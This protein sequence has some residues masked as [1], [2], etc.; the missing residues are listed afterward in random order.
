MS[1]LQY[2]KVKKVLPSP[3]GPL[4]REMPSSSIQVANKSVSAIF[5][6][7]VAM[8]SE[9]GMGT[10]KGK[11]VTYEKHSPEEKASMGNYAVLH[12]IS[13]A[14]RHFKSKHP[15]LKWSTVND[16][17]KAVIAKTKRNY[18]TGQVDPITEL[19]SKKW[20]RPAMLSDELSKDL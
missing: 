7:E 3:E 17:K 20:G 18:Q 13:A 8:R 12:G 5:E 2:F 14:I 16:W 4:S 11:R 15:E 10:K 1:I 9:A 6:S 19:E